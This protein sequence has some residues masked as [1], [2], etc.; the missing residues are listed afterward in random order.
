MFYVLKF[1]QRY[2]ALFNSYFIAQFLKYI[3]YIFFTLSNRFRQISKFGLQ[4]FH[5]LV[6]IDIFI[7]IY[8][9]Y[10]F[11]RHEGKIFLAYFI[12][13][14]RITE[15]RYIIVALQVEHSRRLPIVVVVYYFDYVFL[16]KFN[17][18]LPKFLPPTLQIYK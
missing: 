2:V 6:R 3:Q 18:L 16:C 8:K 5:F 12:K 9:L 4:I 11:V 10:V 15:L 14:S 17:K 13:R 1:V 7:W